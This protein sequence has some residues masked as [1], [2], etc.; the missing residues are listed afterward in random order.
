MV[1][2]SIGCSAQ[3]ITQRSGLTRTE[4]TLALLQAENRGLVVNAVPLGTAGR[5]RDGGVF[6][7]TEEGHA[8][9]AGRDDPPAES[10]EL[11]SSSTPGVRVRVLDADWNEV[12]TYDAP[13]AADDGAWDRAYSAHVDRG[14]GL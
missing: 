4:V 2:E 5:W 9:L 10:V 6:A 11:L 1:G 12:E 7:L 8:V 13:A 3:T 14:L